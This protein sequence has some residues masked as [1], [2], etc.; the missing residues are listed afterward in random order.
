MGN[1]TVRTS[2]N[3]ISGIK[4]KGSNI[5]YDLSDDNAREAIESIQISLNNNYDAPS[6]AEGLGL[7][8]STPQSGDSFQ[9]AINKLNNAI[10]ADETVINSGL[11]GLDDR[12][13]NI[14]DVIAS[15]ANATHTHTKS[16]I[17]DLGTIGTAASKNVPNS[18]DASSSQVVMGNDSRLSDSRDPNNHA[19][20]K[21][22][23]F[24]LIRKISKISLCSHCDINDI[25][26]YNFL[27][28]KE[29][30]ITS[31]GSE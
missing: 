27:N 8:D 3:K 24:P 4:L 20:N 10:A 5:K 1:A 16:Q 22:T 28:K 2:T 13:D 21:V 18:G 6:A 12:I 30:L 9:T 14:E 25:H 19:S 17:T 23:S 7:D 11:T 29:L 31:F 26:L 15:K